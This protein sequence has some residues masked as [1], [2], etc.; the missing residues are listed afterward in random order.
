[1]LRGP[2]A[3]PSSAR[4]AF[5]VSRGRGGQVGRIH[6]RH[7]P[8]IEASGKQRVQQLLVDPSQPADAHPFA[9]LVQHAHVR[10]GSPIGQVREP[11]PGSLFGQQL[12]QEVERVDGSEQGQE[13]DSPQLGRAKAGSAA[14]SVRERKGLIDELVGDVR[15]EFVE[16]SGGAGG[17]E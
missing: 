14:A 12:Q 6:Q 8:A 7:R 15:R 4:Y 2:L 16:Q 10:D 13:V 11:S 1:M 9:K 17:W 3:S 5:F